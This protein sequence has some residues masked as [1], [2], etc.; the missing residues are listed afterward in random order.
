VAGF[1]D[2]A[3]GLWNP[4]VHAIV[5]GAE[6]L[7]DAARAAFPTFSRHRYDRLRRLPERYAVAGDAVCS[8]DPRFGQGMTVAAIEA[9]E[10]GRVLD[11]HGLDRIGLRALAAA[12]WAVQDAWDLAAG[13][14]LADP[15]VE[16]PR[17]ASWRLTNAYLQRLIPVAHHDP[18][19][20][21]AFARVVGMLARP[22]ELMRP[23][24]LRRVLRG[25][26]RRGRAPTP[27]VA[28]LGPGARRG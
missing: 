5:A 14:D 1:T 28:L 2:Y 10:L 20:A 7:G 24:V 15:Q 26:R 19:V 12:R 13:S 17:P 23:S 3:A 9:A 22:P 16:G 4:D 25:S 21:E 6:P 18:V 27:S 11:T 8:F